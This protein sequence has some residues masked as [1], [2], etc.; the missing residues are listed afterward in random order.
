[1]SKRWIFPS[2]EIPRVRELAR[3]LRIS[4]ITARMLVNR[5]LADAQS[6][7]RF[8]QP[9]L[10]ELSDPADQP[11]LSGAASFLCEAV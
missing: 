8:L 6:A 2:P 9:S 5:G 1:M 11:A 7:T 4:E 10:H 3:A